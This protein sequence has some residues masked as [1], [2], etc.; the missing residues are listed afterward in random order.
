MPV[1]FPPV[2][3]PSYV[4]D[5]STAGKKG[6]IRMKNERLK[7]TLVSLSH[8]SKLNSALKLLL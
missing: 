4:S 6:I 5:L 2:F 7:Y 8:S 3:N 1:I